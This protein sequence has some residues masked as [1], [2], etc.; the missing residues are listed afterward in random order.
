M[1]AKPLPGFDELLLS[2][3]REGY[4]DRVDRL[5]AN[6]FC[7]KRTWGTQDIP[8]TSSRGEQVIDVIRKKS[9]KIHLQQY[10]FEK[11]GAATG[12]RRHLP[13]LLEPDTCSQPPARYVQFAHQ[14]SLSDAGRNRSQH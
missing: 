7:W 8:S 3:P 13:A 2:P 9:A 11:L 5:P 14:G 1:Y 10:D 12:F 6:S 4:V